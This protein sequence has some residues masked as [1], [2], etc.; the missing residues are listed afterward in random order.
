MF[1]IAVLYSVGR[2]LMNQLTLIFC[3]LGIPSQQYFDDLDSETVCG[4]IR[5][6]SFVY[7]VRCRKNDLKTLDL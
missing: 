3:T 2:D 7:F 4:F 1:D 5:S 6:K